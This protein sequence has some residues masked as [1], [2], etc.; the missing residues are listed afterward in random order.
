M[1]ELISH[2]LP[3]PT[4]TWTYLINDNPIEQSPPELAF[5]ES[6]GNVHSSRTHGGS[7]CTTAVFYCFCE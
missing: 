5:T 6:I 4:T 7:K 1:D 3:R 2:S